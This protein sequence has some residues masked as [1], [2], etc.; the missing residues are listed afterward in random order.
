L[1]ARRRGHRTGSVTGEQSAKLAAWQPRRRNERWALRERKKLIFNGPEGGQGTRGMGGQKSKLGVV[2]KT[3]GLGRLKTPVKARGG[4][5]G[6]QIDGL[7]K[8]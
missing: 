6:N 1:H 2:R 7:G 3:T 5:P 8:D 4:N